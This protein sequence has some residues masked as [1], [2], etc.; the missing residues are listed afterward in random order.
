MVV[1]TKTED[2]KEKIFKRNYVFKVEIETIT[3]NINLVPKITIPIANMRMTQAGALN[4]DGYNNQDWDTN[5]NKCVYDYIIYRYGNVKGLIKS[6]SYEKLEEIFDNGNSLVEGVNTWGIR[7]FCVKFGIYLHALDE[8]EHRF[9][10]YVPLKIKH[11]DYPPMIF[12]VSNG[13]F[14]PIPKERI[15][16]FYH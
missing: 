7:N 1:R 15:K 14:Y 16:V 3:K 4:Y 6:C 8:E 9:M 5:T 10:H 12:K 11:K 2:L 13:H